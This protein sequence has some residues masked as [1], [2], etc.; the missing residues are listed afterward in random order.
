MI[1]FSNEECRGTYHSH[2]MAKKRSRIDGDDEW[3]L[4]RRSTG[5]ARAP[6]TLLVPHPVTLLGRYVRRYFEDANSVVRPFRGRI[7]RYLT[8][9]NRVF[10]GIVYN[11]KDFEELYHNQVIKYL[12]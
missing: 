3:R 12:R 9:G 2:R 11:D 6:T 1:R 4:N 8:E 7:I 10:Y 5:T